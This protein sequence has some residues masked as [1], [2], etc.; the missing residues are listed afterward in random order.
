MTQQNEAHFE[1]KDKNKDKI[2]QDKKR[3][4]NINEFLSNK[5]KIMLVD[6]DLLAYRITSSLE[7]PI[8]WGDDV[9]TLWSDLKKGKQLFLQS[10]GFYLDLTKSFKAV[11]CFS[12]RNNF[13]KELDS[14]YKSFRKKI[15]KPICY[16]PLR[17]WIEETHETVSY[18]N[19]EGDDV[20][21]LLAT[22]KYKNNCVIVSGDKDMRTIPCPQVCIVD[23]QIEIVDE[24]NADYNFCTQVLK[25]DS[26]DGYTGLVGCGTIKA[27][28]VLLDK[29]KLNEQW[30]A[31]LREYT[32]AKYSID[33]AYH[34][35]RLAR[36]LRE[37][38]YNYA[39]NKPKLWDYKYEYYRHFKESRKAS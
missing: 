33:D 28:R 12:D 19:L 4:K 32:R 10:I 29:K 30:E 13:R 38:E 24:N 11:I 21:G 31:V 39:T 14:V 8:D 17:E 20:I 5:G 36:I 3:M 16:K 23:D 15:R 6:G 9:W 27:S 35:A 2:Y 7:E 37:G 1:V 18:K 25:G 26:S 22:G 34:Q